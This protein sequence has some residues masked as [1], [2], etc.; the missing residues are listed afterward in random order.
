[1]PKST[2]CA[3][4]R[5]V[6]SSTPVVCVKCHQQAMDALGVMIRNLQGEVLTEMSANAIL[7]LFAES[8]HEL[9]HANQ[10]R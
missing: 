7:S 1:M 3:L 5:C 8:A 6:V 10:N 9:H 2:C 4:C